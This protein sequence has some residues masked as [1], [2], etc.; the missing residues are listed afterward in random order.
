MLRKAGQDHLAGVI[1]QIGNYHAT[2]VQAAREANAAGVGLLVYSHMG[3]IPP[4]NFLTR[5]SFARGVSDVRPHSGWTI[6]DDGLMLTLPVGSRA[7][8]TSSLP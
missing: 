8:E 6:A 5:A 2:P 3:P 4:D 1:N 7:I